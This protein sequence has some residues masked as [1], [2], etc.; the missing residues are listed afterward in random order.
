MDIS[1]VEIIKQMLQFMID[2]LLALSVECVDMF[3]CRD[4]HK[5]IL[6]K[7]FLI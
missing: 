4:R 7:L 3:S 6:I 5:K 1:F 2:Y